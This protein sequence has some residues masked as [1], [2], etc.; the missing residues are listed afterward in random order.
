MLKLKTLSG[1]LANTFRLLSDK[2]R[3]LVLIYTNKFQVFS[4]ES[5]G[6]GTFYDKQIQSLIQKV[7]IKKAK[8]WNKSS[9]KSCVGLIDIKQLK[10]RNLWF[11][12]GNKD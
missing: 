6:F 2:H 9:M 7:L 5:Y 11:I 8:V 4:G 10:N 3:M 12:Q 1:V